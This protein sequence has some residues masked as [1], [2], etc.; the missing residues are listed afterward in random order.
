MKMKKVLATCLAV[1]AAA[2]AQAQI[3][4]TY[5]ILLYPEGQGKDVGIVENG[6]QLTLGPGESNGLTGPERDDSY[7]DISNV[8][9]MA[10][11]DIYLPEKGNGQMVIDCPGGG[12]EF[13]SSWNE[14]SRAAEWFV[15]HGIA[16]CVVIYRL[17]NHH[18]T[19]PLTDVQNAFRYCRSHSEEWGIKQIGVIGYSAGG[20]LAACASTLYTDE[21]T[22]P[23]F[24]VLLYPVITMEK[25]VTHNGTMKG[26]TNG[27]PSLKKYYSMENHVNADTPTT[28]ILLS[29]DDD[30]V[31]PEN[32]LR[33]YKRLQQYGVP[34]ELHIFTDGG[35][36]W[37]FT[38]MECGGVNYLSEEQ[39]ADFFSILE[40][41][42]KSLE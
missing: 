35:H 11:M 28:L 1:I 13:V 4:P 30:I 10:R 32:S 37:G 36:G 5:S 18:H 20:H 25:S 39:R 9:D 24:S 2:G 3:K 23:D 34:S 26:L 29:G 38:T 22:K 21:V 17:P 6:V 7:G 8:G 14:G 19:V 12:Y 33:Y 31:P 42:L 15:K 40:R 41:W 16:C 27:K